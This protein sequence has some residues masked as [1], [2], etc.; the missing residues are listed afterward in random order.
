MIDYT[1]YAQLPYRDQNSHSN[2]GFTQF[3]RAAKVEAVKTITLNDPLYL[4]N[5]EDINDF[6]DDP[7]RV[8]DLQGK[9][10]IAGGDMDYLFCTGVNY[11]GPTVTLKNAVIDMNHKTFKTAFNAKGIL[12]LENVSVINAENTNYGVMSWS[13]NTRSYQNGTVNNEHFVAANCQF[14]NFK[15]AAVLQWSPSFVQSELLQANAQPSQ[16]KLTDCTF[17]G[18]NL[19]GYGVVGCYGSIV[20]DDCTFTGYQGNIATGFTSAND[21]YSLPSQSAMSDYRLILYYKGIPNNSPSAAILL[22][23]AAAIRSVSGNSISDC[24]NGILVWTGEQNFHQYDQVPVYGYTAY[25]QLNGANILAQADSAQVAYNYLVSENSI[26]LASGSSGVNVGIE[27]AADRYNRI[28]LIAGSYTTAITTINTAI[29]AGDA[30][31]TL[32]ALKN[33]IAAIANISADNASLYQSALAA[34]RTDKGSTLTKTEI[35]ALIDQVNATTLTQDTESVASVKMVLLK[36]KLTLKLKATGD[37]VIPAKADASGVTAQWTAKSGADIARITLSDGK[38]ILTTQPALGA[39]DGS[40]TLTL[41]LSKGGAI[42]TL[43]Y[44]VDIYPLGKKVLIN[45][46][47]E[48]EVA[49]TQFQ[50]DCNDK[51]IKEIIINQPIGVG[52]VITSDTDI[53][54]GLG[55]RV[56]DENSNVVDCNGKTIKLEADMDYMLYSGEGESITLQNAVIDL[57]HK[58]AESAIMCTGALKLVNVSFINGENVNCGVTVPDVE[59]GILPG[60]RLIEDNCEFGNFKLSAILES[61]AYPILVSTGFNSLNSAKKDKY[62]GKI[63]A[64]LTAATLTNCTFDGNDQPGFGIVGCFETLTV[65]DCTFKGY[66]GAVSTGTTWNNE[67][68]DGNPYLDYRG[69]PDETP[70]AAI[71]LKEVSTSE[72]SGNKIIDCDNGI[73]IWTGEKDFRHYGMTPNSNWTGYVEANGVLI[74]DTN[75]AM[76]AYEALAEANIINLNA[77][78]HGYPILIED[79]ADR[80]N[81]MELYTQSIPQTVAPKEIIGFTGL[82]AV[83]LTADE[84]LVDLKALKASGKLP[85]TVTVTDGTT[86]A[87]VTI[88]DWTGTFDGATPDTYKLTAVWTMPEGYI[89]ATSPITV[90]ERVDVTTVQTALTEITDFTGLTAVDINTDEQLVDLTALKASGKLP[91]TVTVTDGTTLATAAI[92]DWTGL[93]DGTTPG[94][95]TLTAVWTMP[96]GYTDATSPIT[97]T[98]I[99]N[100]DE[101]DSGTETAQQ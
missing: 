38:A 24:D 73:L 92:T 35:Q 86:P 15:V 21:F 44:A 10:I 41:T 100:V 60:D 78:S 14:S 56:F 43:E 63:N 7:N 39:A 91:G 36:S 52:T 99:V 87:T 50:N 81:R 5:E 46:N 72:I 13:N 68:F 71:L 29:L 47:S 80:Y 37:I 45:D 6:V 28:S 76:N 61:A 94:T 3:V 58:N 49:W 65:E 96:E 59:I 83:D 9:T 2:I 84:Q 30:Q 79:A 8:I 20:I 85:T 33:D 57:D 11:V 34:A 89:D 82:T 12:H 90:T 75:T 22:K 17:D 31:A 74:N 1:P 48:A 88:D 70:S 18:G 95:Y 27:N 4:F 51:K 62:E 101:D 23:E 55:F 67:V 16:V 66:N 64:A 97:V 26:T 25:V 54:P 98:E 77:N 19:P 53:H 69:I 40:V 42:D 93:Y 32:T